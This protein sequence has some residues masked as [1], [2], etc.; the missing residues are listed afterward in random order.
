RLMVVELLEVEQL[1]FRVRREA[2]PKRGAALFLEQHRLV[3]PIEVLTAV[4]ELRDETTLIR[5]C[6]RVVGER[7]ELCIVLGEHGV[8]GRAK[9]VVE[10]L[11]PRVNARQSGETLRVYFS[12]ADGCAH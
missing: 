7:R 1:D 4:D 10:L 8:E 11:Y 3:V 9:L 2:A 12:S 5:V 6:N